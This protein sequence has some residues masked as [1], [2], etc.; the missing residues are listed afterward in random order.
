MS[1]CAFEFLHPCSFNID[2]SLTPGDI[3][4]LKKENAQLRQE[5]AD[6]KAHHAQEIA[7]LKAHYEQ[8]ITGLKGFQ[9]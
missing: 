4:A 9:Q 5:I 8:E 7:D 3:V 6:L 2:N 1:S